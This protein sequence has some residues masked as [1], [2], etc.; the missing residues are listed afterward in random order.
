[1]AI[2]I[3]LIFEPLSMVT[4]GLSGV[5]I[6]VKDVTK[7]IVKNGIPIG[8]T[9]TVLN[10]PLFLIA[11]KQKGFRGM[12]KI[13]YGMSCFSL[14]LFVVPIVPLV[15]EDYLM[16]SL[17]GGG[18]MGVGLGLVFSQG[19]STG[20]TDLLSL[21]LQDWFPSISVA[22]L[23]LLVDGIIVI[24]G[25][26]LFGLQ[27]AM[28]AVVAV[29]VTTK[30]MDSILEGLSFAKQVQIITN[31]GDEIGKR[32]LVDIDRGVTKIPGKGMYTGEGRDILMC[33]LSRNEVPLINKIV[34]EIDPGAFV[35]VSDIR[36]VSGEGFIKN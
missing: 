24:S 31:Y 9:T 18:I 6:I 16:G 14:A 23:L 26:S 7:G 3:N 20:G 8:V 34:H 4:G 21:L 36:E 22:K 35:I 19:M 25:A 15:H 27:S 11:V 32:I 30:I 29:F 10:I 13:L 17:F 2:A 5:A 1:M 33:I 28:Y 12:L